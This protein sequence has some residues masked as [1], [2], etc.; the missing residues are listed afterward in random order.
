[1]FQTLIRW[2]GTRIPQLAQSP[3]ADQAD[4]PQPGLEMREARDGPTAITGSTANKAYD[5]DMSKL[6]DEELV[7]LAKEC[8]YF[9]A[10]QALLT[11]YYAWM[12]RQ[13]VFYARPVQLGRE[14]VEDA[15]A[16]GVSS[17]LEAIAKY[18][19]LQLGK[20]SGCSFR[21]FLRV[22]LQARFRDF[23]KKVWRIDGRQAPATITAAAL[24]EASGRGGDDPVRAAQWREQLERLQQALAQLEGRFRLLWERLAAGASLHELAGELGVSYDCVRRWRHRML[25]NLSAQLQSYSA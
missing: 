21:S 24:E 13:I 17:M 14:D 12:K 16:E 18:D 9:P 5:L 15:Q 20:R 19:T 22:V 6:R 1:M 10:R 3:R 23:L 8:G 11:R 2:D 25:A 4:T 7:V